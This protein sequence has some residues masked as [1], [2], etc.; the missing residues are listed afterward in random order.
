MP[1]PVDVVAIGIIGTV[2]ATAAFLPYEG[3]VDYEAG[4]I[5]HIL[6]F[7][8][9]PCGRLEICMFLQTSKCFLEDFCTPDYA[10][11]LPHKA[12][13]GFSDLSRICPF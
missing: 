13:N 7:K 9:A 1:A 5:Q 3:A 12:T 4:E 2:M 10:H 8:A 6:Q 11:L